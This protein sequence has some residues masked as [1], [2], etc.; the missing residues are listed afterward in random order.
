MGNYQA[1]SQPNKDVRSAI[2]EAACTVIRSRGFH[3]S[4]ITDIAQQAGISYGLVY[5]YFRSKA[6]LFDAIF[7][8]WWKGLF[9]MMNFY[10]P[11]KGVLTLHSAANLG[12]ENDVAFFLGASGSGKTTLS[13]DPNMRSWHRKL[14]GDDTHGW[15][16]DGT[17]NLENGVYAKCLNLTRKDEPDIYNAIRF[18]AILENVTSNEKREV[19]FA[20]STKTTNSRVSYPLEFVHNAIEQRTLG[21]WLADVVSLC[22]T[23]GQSDLC[24]FHRHQGNF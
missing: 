21:S 6:A 3:Q 19:I 11:Q 16:D 12:K 4:R 2:F 14:I 5:H 8:E 7:N 10:L 15:S 23:D 17:F 13:H 22:L 18:G 1:S 20:D 24:L 9:S